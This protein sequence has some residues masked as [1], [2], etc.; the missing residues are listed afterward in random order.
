[1]V[2]VAEIEKLKRYTELRI[3]IARI[4]DVQATIVPIIIGA[5]GSTLLNLKTY[6]KKVGINR[7]LRCL[8]LQIFS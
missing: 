4:W 6:N 1:M 2:K 8:P 7:I 3:E 5:L